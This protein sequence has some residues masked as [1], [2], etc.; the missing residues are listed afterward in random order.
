[1][2][3]PNSYLIEFKHDSRHLGF[4]ELGMLLVYADSF[5]EACKKIPNFKV[6]MHNPY[7]Y[8]GKGYSWIETFK[9][10]REFINLTLE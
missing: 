2:N 3:R 5:E 10:P 8:N 1:M 7:A 9:N 4:N 6:S